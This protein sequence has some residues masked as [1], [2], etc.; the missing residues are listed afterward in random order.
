MASVARKE[1]NFFVRFRFQKQ[2]YKRSLKVRNA[3]AD[4]AKA[5]VEQTLYRLR[6]GQLPGQTQTNCL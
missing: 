3:D 6:T 4:C 5:I 2:Q 1:G